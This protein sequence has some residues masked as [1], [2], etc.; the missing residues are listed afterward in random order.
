MRFL[1][2]VMACV[3]DPLLPGV[4]LH[5]FCH[6]MFL[7]PLVLF[8]SLWDHILTRFRYSFIQIYIYIMN[9]EILSGTYC[10]DPVRHK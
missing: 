5:A 10:A 2:V 4:C 8:L 6:T 1:R 7:G 3:F 9:N